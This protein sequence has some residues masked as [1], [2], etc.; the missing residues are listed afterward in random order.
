MEIHHANPFHII[1]MFCRQSVPFP[2]YC[3]MI[4][5]KLDYE[6][7][8]AS[9]HP[10][11]VAKSHVLDFVRCHLFQATENMISR[12]SYMHTSIYIFVFDINFLTSVVLCRLYDVSGRLTWH[13]AFAAFTKII[14]TGN[15]M[16]YNSASFKFEFCRSTP[17]LRRG[18]RLAHLDN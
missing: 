16:R 13:G 14:F 15:I 1:H 7:H 10:P 12:R 9:N 11:R 17:F 4:R 5:P 3:K 2:L 18:Y 6:L 8:I